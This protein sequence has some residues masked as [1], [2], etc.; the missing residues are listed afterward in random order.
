MILYYGFQVV[1]WCQKSNEVGPWSIQILKRD[2]TRDNSNRTVT[3]SLAI[4][5]V[6]I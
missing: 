4:E 2:N 3:S 5:V 1:A 6:E